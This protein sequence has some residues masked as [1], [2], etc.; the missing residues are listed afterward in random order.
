MNLEK[1]HPP[2]SKDLLAP[3]EWTMEI[4]QEENQSTTVVKRSG[5]QMCRLSIAPAAGTK[6]SS[7]HAGFRP[8][9]TIEWA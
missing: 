9:K 7:I 3:A 5:T 2:V 6:K 8:S 1:D 4:Q